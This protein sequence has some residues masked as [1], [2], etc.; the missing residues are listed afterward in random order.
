MGS[1]PG[2][3]VLNGYAQSWDVA[4]L[5]VTDG[6]CFVS[7]GYQNPTLT[8]MAITARA[9]DYAVEQLRT[10]RALSA[11]RQAAGGS[12]DAPAEQ[13][14]ACS[15]LRAIAGGVAPGFARS[16][17]TMSST[18]SASASSI[19]WESQIVLAAACSARGRLSPP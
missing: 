15:T 13:A 4:N 7:S 17:R 3:S 19:G 9:C 14:R 8:M 18:S 16:A 12:G 6:S 1:D 11:A 10:R 5:F 2:S